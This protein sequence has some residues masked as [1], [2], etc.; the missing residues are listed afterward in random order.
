[1]TRKIESYGKPNF[2]QLFR[3]LQVFESNALKLN[4]TLSPFFSLFRKLK[5]NQFRVGCEAFHKQ[6]SIVFLPL[7]DFCDVMLQ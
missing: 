7:R 3:A 4:R 2:L 5:L 1:V 6:A